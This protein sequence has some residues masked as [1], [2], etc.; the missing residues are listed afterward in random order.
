MRSGKRAPPRPS[1]WPGSPQPVRL[2]LS[3]SFPQT[4]LRFVPNKPPF[5]RCLI[6]TETMASH[7][8]HTDMPLELVHGQT[9][10]VVHAWPGPKTGKA[11]CVV[12]EAVLKHLGLSGEKAVT[13]EFRPVEE[14]RSAD[15]VVIDGPDSVCAVLPAVYDGIVVR[16]GS[17]VFLWGRA[18]AVSGPGPAFLPHTSFGAPLFPNLPMSTR[19]TGSASITSSTALMWFSCQ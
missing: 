15:R 10:I 2:T 7:G 19:S 6:N 11:C 4:G 9:S 13:L 12:D 18:Y 17:V 8:I 3:S 1:D 14:F 5:L 16:S